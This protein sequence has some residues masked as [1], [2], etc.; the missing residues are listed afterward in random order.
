MTAVIFRYCLTL[1]FRGEK[2]MKKEVMEE[3]KKELDEADF[4]KKIRKW[5]CRNCRL[6]HL[7]GEE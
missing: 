3:I 5:I 7:H 6:Y 4:T 1:A 2:D